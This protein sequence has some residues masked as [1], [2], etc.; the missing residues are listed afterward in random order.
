MKQCFIVII[1]FLLILSFEFSI[2]KIFLALFFDFGIQICH[3]VT[4]V[5]KRAGRPLVIFFSAMHI[6]R[7]NGAWLDFKLVTIPFFPISGCMV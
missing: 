6:K 5:T 3:D 7:K 2:R 1:L 4:M